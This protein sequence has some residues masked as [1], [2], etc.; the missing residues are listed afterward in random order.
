MWPTSTARR[1]S[2]AFIAVRTSVKMRP[3]RVLF[4]QRRAQRMKRID[5]VHRERSGFEVR[6]F[7]RPHMIGVRFAALQA[8]VRAELDHD[9][10]DFQQRIGG[11]IEAAGFDVDDH[12][13]ELAEAP[14]HERRRR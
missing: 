2:C 5:A 8:S 10:G 14:A 6:A 11:A 3:E 4:R 12:R 1:Q 9:R 7:E 13:Q